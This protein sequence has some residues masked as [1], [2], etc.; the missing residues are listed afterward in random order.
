MRF[1]ITVV[2]L[3][4]CLSIWGQN[5]KSFFTKGSRPFI[6]LSKV[7]I[8]AYEQD[9]ISIKFKT[10]FANFLDANTPTK[11]NGI[12]L[13]GISQIDKLNRKYKIKDAAPLF[14]SLSN[15]RTQLHKEWGFHLWYNISLPPNADI[16]KIIEAYNKTGLLEVVEPVYKI[17][18][19]AINSGYSFSPNDI[20]FIQQWNLKNTGQAGGTAGKDLSITDA[21]DMEKGKPEVIVAMIDRG[22]QYNH[23]DLSQN[24]WSGIGYNFLTNTNI[25]TPEEH[26]TCT[27][28]VVGAT[29]N[30]NIGVSGIAGGDG[31]INSGI[32]LMSC[33]T[34][35]GSTNGGFAEALVWAADHGACI[36][37][38]SW[39]FTNAG[40]YRQSVLDAIDY[41]CNY[42][43]GTVL[44]GGIVIAAAG[45]NGEERLTYPACYERVI[46]VASTNNKDLLSSFSNYGNWVDIAAPGGDGTG[47]AADIPSTSITGYTFFGGTSAATPHVAGVAALVAS[48]L[49]GKAS[50]SDVRNILLSTTDDIYTLNQNYIGKLGTGRVNA[51]KALQKAQALLVANTIAPPSSFTGTTDCSNIKLS[52]TKNTAGNDVIIAYSESNGIGIPTNGNIYNVASSIASGGTIIYKGN[53]TELNYTIPNNKI[54]QY[55]K[56]WSVNATN[57]YSFGKQAEILTGPMYPINDNT[58]YEEGFEGPSFPYQSLKIS[59]PDNAIT[60]VRT[61]ALRHNG[62]IC[63]FINNFG[64]NNIGQVD[65]MFLPQLKVSKA[66]SIKLSFWKAY[67]AAANADSLA[68]IVSTDCGKTYKTVWQKGGN[69]LATVAGNQ[70]TAYVAANADWKKQEITFG[71]PVSTEKVMIGFKNSNGHGQIL[72]LDDIRVTTKTLPEK[73]RNDGILITPNPFNKQFTVQHYLPPIDLKA[74]NI[75]N[76]LGQKVFSKSYAGNADSYM[77]F[78]MGKLTKG[79]YHVRFDYTNNTVTKKIV[80]L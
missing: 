27:A 42:G 44:Q 67:K 6:D 56:I 5:S 14:S 2:L 39:V 79:V 59:N 29:S 15:Y 7:P 63:V 49:S 26:G 17:A 9:K 35:S 25:I 50:A 70:S 8:E 20:K 66:D 71:I 80:K 69:D 22:I 51:F 21:W 61:D 23:P 53:G 58:N 75:F 13:F 65:T 18:T 37:S 73:L 77:F 30:N 54:F 16:K 10:G 52:W 68:I 34:F 4:T 38:N 45:N 74:I 11:K 47:N 24:M 57:Q 78:D 31:S 41:F 40:V 76:S 36:A 43:G 32:R 12:L 48:K 46:G 64:Y 3:F 55:F 62:S 60:W 1:I 33:Q 19:T 72:Y 28:G